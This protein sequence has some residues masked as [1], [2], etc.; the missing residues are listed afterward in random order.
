MNTELSTSQ[1]LSKYCAIALPTVIQCSFQRAALLINTI[2]AGQINDVSK[3]A[4]VGLAVA[5]SDILCFT[6]LEGMNGA[7]ETLVSQ[8]YGNGQLKLCGVH[9]N[10]G[11]LILTA[12]FIPLATLLM[13]SEHIL[14]FIGQ[15]PEVSAHTQEFLRYTLPAIYCYCMFDLTKRFL[16]C[17][18]ISWVPMTAQIVATVLHPFW[19][20]HF[21]VVR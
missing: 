1:L 3:L 6:F 4:G 13:F 19:C 15:D 8:A 21:V 12:F 11:R 10:R 20:Y 2:F 14:I 17:M 18:T 5:I 16:N 9:F 7:A